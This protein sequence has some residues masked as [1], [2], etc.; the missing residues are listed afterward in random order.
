VLQLGM[1]CGL[2]PSEM[3]NSD[4][5]CFREASFRT[6]Y[7]KFAECGRTIELPPIGEKIRAVLAERC[8]IG[9]SFEFVKGSLLLAL[10]RMVADDPDHLPRID[11]YVLRHW[12]ATRHWRNGVSSAWLMQWLHHA[13]WTTTKGY[14]AVAGAV[15]WRPRPEVK[16]KEDVWLPRSALEAP[17]VQEA[18]FLGKFI[19][20]KRRMDYVAEVRRRPD[21]EEEDMPTSEEEDL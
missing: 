18:G 15:R 10:R 17:E 19:A 21:L 6:K 3:R 16:D 8:P 7:S 5:S 14:L 1:A 9:Q 20:R 11:L 4:M 12:A 13:C 2:R